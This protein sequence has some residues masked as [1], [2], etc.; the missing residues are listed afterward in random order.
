MRFASPE[1]CS[2]TETL[3]AFRGIA[4]PRMMR[5]FDSMRQHSRLASGYNFAVVPLVAVAF[6]NATNKS[7]DAPNPL[8]HLSGHHGFDVAL[9]RRLQFLFNRSR[10]LR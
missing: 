6:T 7:T 2:V 8:Y 10:D 5:I 9:E 4:L 3:F 1:Q